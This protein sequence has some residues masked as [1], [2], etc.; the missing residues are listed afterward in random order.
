[1]RYVTWIAGFPMG[2]FGYSFE[3]RLPVAEVVGDRLWLTILLST[4]T[5]IFTW[6][7]A[8]PIG[9]YSATHQYS[10]GITG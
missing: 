2:N 4:F 3:Y 9:I 6:A 1:M 5:I 7:L 10:W 8:F